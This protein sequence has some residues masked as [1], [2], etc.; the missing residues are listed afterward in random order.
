MTDNNSWPYVCDYNADGKKDLLVG[1]EGIGR[2][3]NVYV[4]LNEGTDATPV[5]GDSTPVLFNGV[6]LTYWR[7]IPVLQDL[8]G[9]G[10]HDMTL[11]GWYSDVRFYANSGTNANP[12][13]TTYVYLVMPDSQNYSNGNPPRVNYTDWDGDGD[14]DMITCDYYGSVFLRRNI[15][16]TTVHEHDKEIKALSSFSI[17]PN[18]VSERALFTVQMMEAG[19]VRLDIYNSNGQLVLTPFRQEVGKGELRFSWDI[20]TVTLSNGVYFAQL[21]TKN[22][23]QSQKLLIMR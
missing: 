8:D 11:G 4:Y 23:V 6:P 16:P 1:Q 10:I 9:D 2:P 14:L 7:T 19:L 20:G 17:T 12:I 3:C 21:K 5:F 15:T 13:F 22:S 18:P